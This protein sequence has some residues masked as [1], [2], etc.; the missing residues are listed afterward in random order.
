MKHFLEL[1]LPHSLFN[2]IITIGRWVKKKIRLTSRILKFGT[3]PFFKEINVNGN[4]FFIQLQP[5]KNGC[6]GEIKAT[7]GYWENELS[8]QLIKTLK[9]G[10]TFL[11]IGANIGYHSLL[12]VSILKR[13]ITVHA[14]EPIPVLFKQFEQSIQKNNFTNL[15]LHNFG[16]GDINEDV[17]IFLRDEN[18]GGSSLFEY[19]NLDVVRSSQTDTISLKTLDSVFNNNDKVDVI[20]IDVEGYEFEALKGGENTLKKNS[21][22]IFMEFSPVMYEEDYT[23]KTKKFISYLK[24]LGYLFFTLDEAKIDLLEWFNSAKRTQIDIKCVPSKIVE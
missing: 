4:N 6:V 10:D 24:D 20:K 7:H 15:T 22:I 5:T 14:F 11:D 17:T 2:S 21:P 3:K 1:N 16:L 8:Q 19:K 13:E 23:G 18:M 9:A 12:I